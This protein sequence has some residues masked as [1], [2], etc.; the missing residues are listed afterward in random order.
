MVTRIYPLKNPVQDYAWGSKTA[1]QELLGQPFP[2]DTPAAELWLGAHPKAPSEVQVADR[3]IT[4]DRLI[5]KDPAA[6]LGKPVAEKY[7]GKL[8]FLMKV[9]AAEQPLSIQVHPNLD[10]ARKGFEREN[11]LGLP[12]DAPE[13]NYRDANHKPECLCALTQFEA[14]KGFRPVEEIVRLLDR[15]SL[16]FFS[17]VLKTLA[18][19][20]D[21]S[22]LKRFFSWW[23]NMDAGPRAKAVT[24]VV[25]AA[26]SVL[27]GM[28]ETFWMKA[29]NRRYPGD[30]GVLGPVFFNL[31]ELAP[32]KAVYIPA[33]EP[34]AY[35]K[36]VGVEIMANSDNVIRGGL[37]SKPM[38]V[39]ELLHLIACR[40]GPPLRV[41]VRDEGEERIYLTPAREFALS[42][43]FILPGKPFKSGKARGAEI[44]LCT[45][46]HGALIDKGN[47]ETIPMHKGASVVVP[48]AVSD[49]RI[50]G[51]ATFFRATVK[52]SWRV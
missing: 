39:P 7:D 35:L 50:E 2:S 43:L 16:A 44:L 6:I 4:L 23:M 30:A 52:V 32:G 27:G 31:M 49:Y 24:Q 19:R 18:E 25:K 48:A 17:D 21:P 26:E 40:P 1:I 42:T 36:G 9:L 11:R 22:G 14:L 41:E 8:P 28:R 3:W 10:Q 34:H 47:N 38:D 20:P 13:R 29:F 5:Q 46:G 15:L 12:L 33:G 45:A 37:T 51:E